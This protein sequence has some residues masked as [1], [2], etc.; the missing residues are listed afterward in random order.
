[1][2]ATPADVDRMTNRSDQN[3]RGE[4]VIPGSHDLL[5]QLHPGGGDVVEPADERADVARADFRGDERL[6][7][8]EA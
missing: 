1:M 3:F 6:G 8:R 7:R 5:D 2:R 4:L